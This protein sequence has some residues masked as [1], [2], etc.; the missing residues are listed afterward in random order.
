VLRADSA[1]ATHELVEV[2][3][4]VAAADEHEFRFE[5]GMR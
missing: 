3:E 4:T 5:V 2:R 1:G